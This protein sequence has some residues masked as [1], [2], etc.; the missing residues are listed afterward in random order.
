MANIEFQKNQCYFAGAIQIASLVLSSHLYDPYFGPRRQQ[1]DL[2]DAGF[3]LALSTNGYIP[4]I[5]S[6]VIITNHGRQSWY[7]LLLTLSIFVL[8]TGT[9]IWLSHFWATASRYDDPGQIKDGWYGICEHCDI[10][11]L[12]KAWCG[13]EAADPS[14]IQIFRARGW[15]WAIWAICLCW[16]LYCVACKLIDTVGSTHPRVKTEV[17][18]Y[19]LVSMFTR[20]LQ[21][22]GK[23][24]WSRLGI[25]LFVTT[26]T[27]SFG[28]QFYVYSVVYS[29][30]EVDPTWSF[31]QIVAIT[32]WAPCLVEYLNLELSKSFYGS[33]R[34]VNHS[35]SS[36][37]H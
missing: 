18:S 26:W 12:S 6:L 25:G 1:P 22:L 15:L 8:S 23:K 13:R 3:I 36:A 21:K 32:I 29:N 9:L 19:P 27:L 5:L 34:D 24:N 14:Y 20:A 4:T 11:S 28:Y 10:S 37:P 7:L 30:A 31:G 33:I 35:T 17:Q 16:L 2:L